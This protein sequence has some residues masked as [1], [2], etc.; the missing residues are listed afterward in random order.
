[1]ESKL[2][3]VKEIQEHNTK[4]TCIRLTKLLKEKLVDYTKGVQYEQYDNGTR[5]NVWNGIF[6]KNLPS[7]IHRT[8]K[9]RIINVI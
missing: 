2:S 8:G 4:I 1:M 9:V 3:H 5:T 7:Y 6:S